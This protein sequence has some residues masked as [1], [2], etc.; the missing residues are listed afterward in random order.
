[1]STRKKQ[2]GDRIRI[3]GGQHYVEMFVM[4]S[5]IDYLPS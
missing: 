4:V 3:T 5:R 1:M 2:V